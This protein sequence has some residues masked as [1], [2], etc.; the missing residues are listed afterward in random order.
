MEIHTESHCGAGYSA[1]PQ[2]NQVVGFRA[3]FAVVQNGVRNEQAQ[4][5]AVRDVREGRPGLH[6]GFYDW[7]PG[8][9]LN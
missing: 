8:T 3:Y 4:I 9:I 1:A 2:L 6:K 7:K 5:V